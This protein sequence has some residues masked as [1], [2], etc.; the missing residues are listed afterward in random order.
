MF[1]SVNVPNHRIAPPLAVAAVLFLAGAAQAHVTVVPRSAP[2]GTPA[3]LDFRVFHGCG[4]RPTIRLTVKIPDGFIL[5]APQ[6]KP[7]WKI[8]TKSAPYA[9]TFQVGDRMVKEGFTEVTWSDGLLPA[10]YTDDFSIAGMLPQ[11]PGEQLTLPA[12]QECPAADGKGTESREFAPTV[13]LEAQPE[14]AKAGDK[15]APQGEP[16]KEPGSETPSTVGGPSSALIVGGLALLLSIV[17][18]VRTMRRW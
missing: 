11:R 9:A 14:P 18:L 15:A 2:A 8:S 16:A 5:P 13:K 10:D 6:V 1:E 17:A 4:D 12:V 3:K 7:G